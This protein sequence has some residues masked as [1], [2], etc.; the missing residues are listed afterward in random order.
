MPV[1]S[2]CHQPYRDKVYNFHVAEFECF[3]VGKSSVLVHNTNGSELNLGDF[4]GDGVRNPGI[5]QEYKL[6]AGRED[7][8]RLARA[9]A[10][11]EEEEDAVLQ[12][13]IWDQMMALKDDL[14]KLRQ[15]LRN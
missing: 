9:R 1:E 4:G 12:S 15:C 7:M 8:V 5:Y 10:V 13:Q 11:A 3:A 6:A 14:V 2:I